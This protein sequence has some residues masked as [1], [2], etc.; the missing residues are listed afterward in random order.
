VGNETTVFVYDAMGKLVAEYS[1][2]P[3]PVDPKTSYTAT[4]ILGSPRVITDQYRQVTSRR[5]FLPFGEELSNGTAYRSADQKFTNAD[6]IRQRFT[7]YEKDQET[8]LD[9]A[10]ARYYQN[11]HG[12]FTAVDP[13]L[14][15]GKSADPQTFNRYAYVLNNPLILTDPTGL[16]AGS[17][18][19]PC[20]S[21]GNCS[22]TYNGST[23]TVQFNKP[24]IAEVTINAIN[25]YIF[26]PATLALGQIIN[27]PASL[28]EMA[29]RSEN[30]YSGASGSFFEP[31]NQ[32][33]R[34]SFLSFAQGNRQLT[35]GLN[36]VDPFGLV[37]F[38][39]TSVNASFG[40]ASTAD[41]LFSGGNFVFNTTTSVFGG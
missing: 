31:N 19:K 40:R 10:E 32:V 15:S 16:Q 14:A 20:E 33:L 9:F 2:T 41:V 6:S 17:R 29:E 25:T 37:D 24:T 3:P 7:G 27:Q 30:N 12:R 4:D 28:S 11:R 39:E 21:G 35:N 5:D 1:T 26:E 8:G 18:L 34:N 38:T 22:G 36:Q 23:N 13:L